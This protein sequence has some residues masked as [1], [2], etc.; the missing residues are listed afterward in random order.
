MASAISTRST[1]EDPIFGQL[2]EKLPEDQL[3]Q[4]IEVVCHFLYLKSKEFDHSYIRDGKLIKV[5]KPATKLNIYRKISE[6]LKNE[7]SKASIPVKSDRAIEQ[8]IESV[9]EKAIS[10]CPKDFQKS[11]SS[12][13]DK[14]NAKADFLKTKGFYS[15]F[16]ISLC[17]CFANA[18]EQKDFDLS[19]C[20]C[21]SKFPQRELPFYSE[22]K[23]FRRGK[24]LTKVDPV[25][26]AEIQRVQNREIRKERES[27]AREKQRERETSTID[28]DPNLIGATSMDYFDPPDTE[29]DLSDSD[30]DFQTAPVKPKSRNRNNYESFVAYGKR[31]GISIL[32]LAGLLNA[33]RV[34]ENE[35]DE[36]KF[37]SPTKIDNQWS[38][39]R[40]N[41][42][43]KHSQINN[44]ECIKL[45]GKKG[46][47]KAEHNKEKTVDK[48][49]CVMEPGGSYLHHFDALTG[50][51]YTIAKSLLEVVYLYDSEKSLKAIGGDN[52]ITNT[53]HQGG[54]FYWLQVFLGRPLQIVMCMLH[55]SELPLKHLIRKYV[56]PTSGPRS[57]KSELGKTISNLPNNLKSIV[58]FKPIKGRVSKIDKE[59]LTNADQKYAYYLALGIQNGP[60]FVKEIFGLIPGLCGQMHSARWLNPASY[61]MRLYIQ[62]E[63]P[64]YELERLVIIIVNWYLPVFFL[65][66]K[67]WHVKDAAHNFFQAIQWAQDSFTEEEKK[68]AFKVF[69]RNAYMAHCESILLAGMCHSDWKIRSNCADIIIKARAR[70]SDGI[71]VFKSPKDDLNL[72]ARNF[73]EM[74]DLSK[75]TV[76]DPPLLRNFDN[77][78]LRQFALNGGIEIPDIAC[79][80]VHNERSVKDTTT[81]AQREIGMD[82]THEHILNLIDNREKIPTKPKKSDFMPKK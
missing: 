33:L 68:V 55:F 8:Q 26:T 27:I 41:L 1:T 28:I 76:T 71:R 36:S 16:D 47:V 25:G 4:E 30:E 60:D 74:V 72:D 38:K 13:K 65:I 70:K 10:K 58:N 61:I 39:I 31:K 5:L 37:V 15:L 66:K 43:E 14:R 56:G 24:I 23:L 63:S 59:L 46:S 42:D 11:V 29:I 73:L 51:A 75:S 82:K 22:Q 3:A 32:T 48:I 20:N 77:A 64:S 7:W 2:L 80:S 50:H 21:K 17:Q 12:A 6:A 81:A 78:A 34:D 9:I 49:T 54:V 35:L 52:C 69:K 18:K 62:T 79:H 67:Q 57:W 53:G 19:K 44:V 45:D 40:A